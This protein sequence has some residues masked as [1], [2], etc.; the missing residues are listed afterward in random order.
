MIVLD[1]P[2]EYFIK[3]RN[4][5]YER[6]GISYEENKIYYVK[7]R[8]QQRMQ[9]GGFEDIE[10]YIKHLKLF[11]G[12]GREFQE[13]INLLTVNETYF[14]REFN[15][16]QLFAE[17][18]LDEVVETKRR[19]GNSTIK[20]LCAGCSTGE[21]A[22]T[23]AIIV[24][25]ML[26]DFRR[27]N[28]LIKAIDIDE[29]VL[30]KARKGVY[31]SRSVKDVP[32]AYLKRYFSQPEPGQYVLRP[33]AKEMVLFEHHNLMDRRALRSEEGYD[34]VFCRN[35]LIYFDEISR[36]Q[37]VDKFYGLLNP[38]GF[39]FLGHSESLSRISS[40]FKIRRMNEHLV[41]QR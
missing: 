29:N 26:D 37:V 18:C 21:E 36:K 17:D 5:I 31:D 13:L 40:A 28:I 2:L 9:A 39:I 41:Y 23:L 38:G 4:L 15:Q 11:D 25:E 3:L 30:V 12:N 7:K 8:L 14:F 33:E 20:I 32:P 6:T 24:R 16:L 34:F 10:A 19:N 22:Y 1:L 35:V 27:W